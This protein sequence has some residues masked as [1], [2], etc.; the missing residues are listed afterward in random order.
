METRANIK[1]AHYASNV[2]KHIFN[3]N[4]IH[5]QATMTYILLCFCRY[6]GSIGTF[7][8]KKIIKICHHAILYKYTSIKNK[9]VYGYWVYA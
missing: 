6:V 2:R 3:F 8:T 9:W 7:I 1:Q 4:S 5:I